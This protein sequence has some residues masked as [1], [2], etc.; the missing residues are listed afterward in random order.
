MHAQD[1]AAYTVAELCGLFGVSKQAYY[2]HDPDADLRKAAQE[3]FA[4]QYIQE[5]KA[6]DPGIGGMKL[7]VMYNKT[8]GKENAIGR[9]RFCDIFDR[10]GFKLRRRRRSYRTTD[11]RHDNPL[12]PN[13]VKT[14]IPLR[15]GE[16]L[17][18]D[19]TY[20][21][22]Q[23]EDPSRRFCFASLV[24]DSYGKEL[25]GYSIG[26]SL[27]AKYPLEALSMAMETLEA[28]G[29]DTSHTTHHT[30]RGVQYTC[31]EYVRA[32][33]EKH[34]MIS[35]TETGN[36]KDN[37][38]AERINNTLKNELFKDMVFTSVEQVRQAMK[39]AVPFY[40][41][42]RPHMSLGMKT[43]AEAAR[44][45]G[46]L[47]RAWKSYREEAIDRLKTENEQKEE[48]EAQPA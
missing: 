38:E 11:S 17:V 39:I 33:N 21:P 23:T 25:I 30:D 43:P 4:L 45:T 5:V 2:K 44:C 46:R 7:W 18:A 15:F 16:I 47:E 24:M 48:E 3:E 12:Y 40:N 32:L 13:L 28:R 6:K 19:I 29:V 36:P 26:E 14:V 9:D 42:E 8:F 1:S 31:A 35:M 10:Y 27:S 22:L 41:N 37:P 20:I 34:I